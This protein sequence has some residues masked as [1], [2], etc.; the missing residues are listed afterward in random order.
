MGMYTRREG[1]IGEGLSQR[2][3]VVLHNQTPSLRLPGSL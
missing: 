1:A 2:A 3:L